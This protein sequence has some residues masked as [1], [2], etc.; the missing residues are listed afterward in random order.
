MVWGGKVEEG[1]K[2]KEKAFFSV[3]QVL[4]A[5]AGIEAESEAGFAV[6]AKPIGS[7]HYV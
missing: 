1:R 5:P 2:K 7:S 3:V 4:V 6:V